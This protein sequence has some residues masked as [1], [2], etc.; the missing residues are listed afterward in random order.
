MIFSDLTNWERER[1]TFPA[2]VRRAIERLQQTDLDELPAGRHEFGEPGM[3]LLINEPV[4][5]D[6][7]EVKPETHRL[8]TD[9][10]L[11]LSGRE[12]MRVAKVSEEQVITDDRYETQDIAF[13]DEVHNENAIDMVPGDFVVLFPTDIHRPNCSVEQDIPIRKAVVKVHRDLFATQQQ[14]E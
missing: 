6:W 7:R 3:F 4:T 5:R 8:H 13:Y 9:I 14:N 1:D 2:P 11:L 10:Q 12:R